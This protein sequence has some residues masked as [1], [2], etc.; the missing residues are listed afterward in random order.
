MPGMVFQTRPTR[1]GRPAPELLPPEAPWQRI[2]DE[3][4]WTVFTAGCLPP[5]PPRAA[6]TRIR[7]G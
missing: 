1:R 6:A 7:L 2:A 5:Q 4:P 3:G